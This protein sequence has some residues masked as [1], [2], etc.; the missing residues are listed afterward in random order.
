MTQEELEVTV[1]TIRCVE[2]DEKEMKEK[3][4]TTKKNIKTPSWRVKLESVLK[5]LQ[6]IMNNMKLI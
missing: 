2:E 4:N 3:K 5:C 6:V 1:L